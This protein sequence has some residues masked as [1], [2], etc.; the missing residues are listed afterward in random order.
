[1]ADTDLAQ[2]TQTPSEDLSPDTTESMGD[3]LFEDV[4]TKTVDLP[5]DTPSE[6]LSNDSARHSG[7][8]SQDNDFDLS[9]VDFQRVDVNT[10]PEQYRGLIS[11]VQQSFN[12]QRSDLDRQV[13]TLTQELQTVR[14]SQANSLA[15]NTAAQTIAQLSQV[16]KFADLTPEQKGALD[17][18][19]EVVREENS[20]FQ[21]V[22]ERLAQVTQALAQIQ[23][24]DRNRN[25]NVLLDQ[26]NDAKSRYGN[27]VDVYGNV[28][29]AMIRETN[30]MT[31][32]LYTITEAYESASGRMGQTVDQIN[33]ANTAFRNDSKNQLAPTQSTSAPS[34]GND[35]GSLTETELRTG[36]A[37][38]GFDL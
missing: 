18:V 14:D 10:V 19:R 3:G 21:G 16:D 1:M 12:S 22:P 5:D 31:N 33:A 29:L 13:S 4:S 9:S 25:T 37:N 7:D 6:T 38:L 35:T 15:A 36:L 27:D 17:T 24:A 2:D 11:N 8:A 26:A 32:R 30:P 20:Q 34:M 23:Q 28:I